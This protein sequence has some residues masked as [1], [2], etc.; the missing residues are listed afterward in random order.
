MIL[1]LTNMLCLFCQR[2]QRAEGTIA[3]HIEG[4]QGPC[5]RAQVYEEGFAPARKDYMSRSTL[6]GLGTRPT[7]KKQTR[8]TMV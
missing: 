4:C 6:A 7:S 8:H 1:T 2:L 5:I 3:G